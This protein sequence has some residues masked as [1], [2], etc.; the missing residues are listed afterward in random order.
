MIRM[1]RRLSKSAILSGMVSLA[2]VMMLLQGCTS[3]TVG[4][5][6]ETGGLPADTATVDTD[7]AN[8]DTLQA[9]AGIDF[10]YSDR[11][12]DASYD[13]T[14]ATSIILKQSGSSITGTGAV[15]DG[16]N[17]TIDT[18]GTYV[19][20]GAL[21][22]GSVIVDADA[23][24]KVQL[25][26]DG[27]TVVNSNGPAVLIEQADKV[28]VTLA[29][30]SNN[31]LSDSADRNDLISS[32]TDGED[33]VD[34]ASHDATL[35]SHDDL[36]INGSGTLTVDGNAAHA[37]VSKDDL[38]ITSG[39]YK[40]RAVAD[41][42]QSK[43]CVKILA[44]SFNLDAG[45]DA[46]T[47]TATED[48]AAGFVSIDGGD[49]TITAQ[50]DAIHAETVLRTTGGTVDVANCY[51]GLEGAWIQFQGGEFRITST[52][53]GLNAASD[54]QTSLSLEISGGYLYIN[55][56]GDGIDSNG[57]FA[58]SGGTVIVCGPTR[59]GNGALD[60]MGTATISGGTVLAVGTSDM[61]QGVGG[62]DSTQAS[63]LYS[64]AS[65]IRTGSVLTLADTQGAVLF[66]FKAPKD[67][68]S[69]VFSS[70]ELTVGDSYEIYIDA[71]VRGDES[72]GFS[73]GG[74]MSG[75]TL[76][77][78]FTLSQTAALV[79]ADGT[80]SEMLQGGMGGG[81]GGGGF[82]GQGQVPPGGQGGGGQGTFD[83]PTSGGRENVTINT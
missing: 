52:D 44:G 76:S 1:K 12:Q 69:L 43:D 9:I 72:D 55:T 18:E 46:I 8:G 15:A 22:D 4:K 19:L 36:T 59:E 77:T 37:I 2:L 20:S 63:I 60:Y 57:T 53:D 6:G 32:E 23:E 82:R 10:S 7:S 50:G 41:T 45:D 24:A 65:T 11:D 81:F 29:D 25:V 47:S 66:S 35:F 42:L 58:Q 40:L 51:E 3:S 5:A 56:E 13:S 39:N 34:H 48:V 28:F 33:T 78:S 38:I 74:T 54:Y 64:P 73:M 14:S 70:A 17:V 62:G 71:T 31:T 21:T 61:A 68:S 49:F 83:G 16:A 75:G 79:S 67:Y 80:V 26:L 27:V 30:G